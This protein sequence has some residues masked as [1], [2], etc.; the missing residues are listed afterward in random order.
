[1]TEV[2]F[3]VTHIVLNVLIYLSHDDF[4]STAYFKRFR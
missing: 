2:V 1:M 4:N 3:K